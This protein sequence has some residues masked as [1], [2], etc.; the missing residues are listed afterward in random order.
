MKNASKF[1]VMFAFSLLVLGSQ[2]DADMTGG[3]RATVQETAAANF[4]AF[5]SAPQQPIAR[6]LARQNPEVANNVSK[7]DRETCLLKV[8][9]LTQEAIDLACQR[10]YNQIVAGITTIFEPQYGGNKNVKLFDPHSMSYSLR[11]A[12]EMLSRTE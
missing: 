11:F 3:Q 1:F 7:S 5:T 4:S 12:Q 8:K 2:A 6:V 10:A 9:D